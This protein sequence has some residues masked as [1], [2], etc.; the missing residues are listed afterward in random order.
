MD[1][2]APAPKHWQPPK[3]TTPMT[4]L[5]AITRP[6]H[7]SFVLSCVI[8]KYIHVRQSRS[9]KIKYSRQRTRCTMMSSSAAHDPNGDDESDVSLNGVLSEKDVKEAEDAIGERCEEKMLYVYSTTAKW[10]DRAT[11]LKRLAQNLESWSKKSLKELPELPNQDFA[12]ICKDCDLCKAKSGLKERLYDF[13]ELLLKRDPH[14]EPDPDDKPEPDP[15]DKPDLKDMSDREIDLLQQL[16]AAEAGRIAAD[17]GRIAAEAGRIA[18]IA[19]RIAEIAG[20]IY[21]RHDHLKDLLAAFKR[22]GNETA[23]PNHFWTTKSAISR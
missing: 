12:C 6:R 18:E 23:L 5:S 15:H 21:E 2:K 22:L 20:R 13:G 14:N 1:S 19:G 11:R 8:I 17:A 4:C 10:R 7:D 9:C 3:D 16:E